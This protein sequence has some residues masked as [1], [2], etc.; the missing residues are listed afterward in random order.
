MHLKTRIGSLAVATCLCSSLIQ[1]TSTA[2]ACA[3]GS[4]TI[5][6]Q[7]N[8]DVRGLNN[9]SVTA[10]TRGT[11]PAQP[12]SKQSQPKQDTASKQAVNLTMTPECLAAAAAGNPCEIATS[13]VGGPAAPAITRAQ[14]ETSAQQ[15]TTSLTVPDAPPVIGPDPGVNEWN[16]VAVGQPIWLWT[17][18][19]TNLNASSTQNGI[20]INLTATP[21]STTFDMGDGQQVTC[22]TMTVR[23]N[24]ADPMATSP[25]C[26]YRYQR[27]GVYTVTA[28]TTW[29]INW[30]ALGFSGALTTNRSTSR[31]LDVGELSSVI[32]G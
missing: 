7:T 27:K 1:G 26:G 23:P 29:N 20:A 15:A 32:V 2:F 24:T 25:S 12:A 10:G 3:P 11:V 17:T 13:L 30:S 14:V 4:C 6:T 22:T 19:A 8:S 28:T 21:A 16:M 9:V 18:G 31:Q 5:D